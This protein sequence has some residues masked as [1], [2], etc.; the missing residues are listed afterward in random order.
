LK[1]AVNVSISAGSR[2]S[3]SMGPLEAFFDKTLKPDDITEV[4]K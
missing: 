3:A 1:P 2:C 4:K